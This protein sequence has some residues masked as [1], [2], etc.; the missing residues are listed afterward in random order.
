MPL[1]WMDNRYVSNTTVL[2]CGIINQIRGKPLLQIK[3]FYINVVYVTLYFLLKYI[4][5]A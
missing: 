3:V 1:D 2:N 4:N 5:Q